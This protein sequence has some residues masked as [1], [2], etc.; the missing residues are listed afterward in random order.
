MK[1][2]KNAEFRFLEISNGEDVLA[3][4]GSEGIR[5]YGAQENGAKSVRLHFHNLMEV[6]ICRWGKGEVNLDGKWYPYKSGDIMVIPQ[7]Y[8]HT[9][10]SHGEKSFWEYIYIK[11]SA[12][13]EKAY[14]EDL[15]KKKRSIEG[16]EERPFFKKRENV[17]DLEAEINLLMNQ[18]RIQ[19][20]GYKECMKGLLFALLMEIIKINHI[21]CDKPE[22]KE[23]QSPQ[24]VKALALAFEYIEENFSKELR[25]SDIA[26]AAF[27]SETYLRRLFME[28]C[29]ISPMQYV[30]KIRINAACKM[31]KS[32]ASSISE[33][34]YTVGFENMATFIS[35]FK[36]IK[37]CTPKQWKDIILTKKE[38][39]A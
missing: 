17:P 35:N 4:L 21:D 24:K 6:G 34:A 22:M 9:I 37:G 13:F 14:K 27:V 7:N 5:V 39:S 18:A 31:M 1:N 2:Q 3:L 10:N 8:P 15:R 30:K 38:E 29:A 11:P 33:I 28:S 12:F 19:A 20:H 16:V 32:S 23:R 25:I 26:N 36:K